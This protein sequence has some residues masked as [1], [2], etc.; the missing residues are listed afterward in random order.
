MLIRCTSACVRSSASSLSQTEA[1]HHHAPHAHK[2]KKTF[3]QQHFNHTKISCWRISETSHVCEAPQ[4]ETFAD[5][6]LYKDILEWLSNLPLYCV[7]MTVTIPPPVSSALPSASYAKGTSRR[8]QRF[9]FFWWR[10]VVGCFL[11]M[12]GNSG[13][14]HKVAAFTMEMAYKPPVKASVKTLH[15]R[16]FQDSSSFSSSNRMPNTRKAAHA[17]AIATPAPQSTRVGT[18]DFEQR[19]RDLLFRPDARTKAATT[20]T[21]TRRARALPPNVQTVHSLSEYKNVV[22]EE[23]HRIV[24]VRF[25]ATYC[26]A[27]MAVAPHFYK[28]AQRNPQVSFVEVPVT[29]ANAVLHQGL[30]V[31]SLPYA[32]IYH[33]Q[34]GLVEEMKLTRNEIPAFREKLRQYVEEWGNDDEDAE[35]TRDLVGGTTTHL[36]A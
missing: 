35:D 15:D 6:E 27:C 19:M 18:A 26:R 24:V 12:T 30:G 11:L 23:S 14:I 13:S 34:S 25:H 2:R 28:L 1:T 3:A 36:T 31:P 17:A 33:P 5:C 22:G 10:M 16:R 4:K 21:T 32:H 29:D 20:T 7:T 8:T 9:A